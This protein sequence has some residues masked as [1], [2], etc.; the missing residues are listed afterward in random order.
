MATSLIRH[1]K[2]IK[3]LSLCSLLFRGSSLNLVQFLIPKSS[4]EPWPSV[5]YPGPTLK[6]GVS[7]V[8][9]CAHSLDYW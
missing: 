9:V 1:Y 3:K 4:E 5:V 2:Y 8:Q 6:R 7:Q